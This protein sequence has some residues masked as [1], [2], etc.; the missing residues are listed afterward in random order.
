MSTIKAGDQ[1][2]TGV[3]V[4]PSIAVVEAVAAREGVDPRVLDP[5]LN[6]VV[7]GDAL[8]SLF[9]DGLAAAEGSVS[10]T[11]CGYDVTVDA[12][13]DVALEE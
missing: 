1:Q 5:P 7:D 3:D 6:E 12:D 9:D 4:E 10:F 2:S 13:G 8:N 11:F